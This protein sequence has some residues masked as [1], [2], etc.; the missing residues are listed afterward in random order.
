VLELDENA[1]II[2]YEEYYPYGETSYRAGRNITETG[3]KRYRYTGKEKDEESGLYYYGA[4]YYICWLGRWT[5]ADPAGLVDGLNLYMYCRGSP[6][7]LRDKNGTSG[8]SPLP[9]L[10]PSN[11]LRQEV[12]KIVN[13]ALYSAQDVQNNVISTVQK[14]IDF[15]DEAIGYTYSMFRT[16]KFIY[17]HP[18]EAEGIGP[19][20]KNE[21]A[22]ISSDAERFAEN[23]GLHQ[24]EEGK[25]TQVN[26]FRHVL[27]QAT[28]TSEYNSDIAKKIGDSHEKNPDAATGRNLKTTFTTISKADET[29]DLLNNIIGRE[30]GEKYP[31]ASTN[32]LALETLEYF[33]EHGMWTVAQSGNKYII[34]QEKLSVANYN[35]AKENLKNLDESGFEPKKQ[36]MPLLRGEAVYFP[37]IGSQIKTMRDRFW[38][39][40]K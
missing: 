32:G 18:E 5:A 26:A 24:N 16:I 3:Q 11:M 27:W 17:D 30:I 31:N 37:Y 40:G 21:A 13:G 29:V 28:I 1:S 38:N 6:V 20:L 10:E 39:S 12:D 8:G 14:S 23:S 9:E 25:G 7:G 2:C 36:P 15:I 34:T 19:P 22:N 35:N 4:R 33:K